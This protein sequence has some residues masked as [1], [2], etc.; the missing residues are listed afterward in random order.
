RQAGSARKPRIV[1]VHLGAGGAAQEQL[2]LTPKQ[3]RIELAA[4]TIDPVRI[5]HFNRGAIIPY[6]VTIEHVMAAMNDFIDFIQMVNL[7]LHE[8]DATR[9]EAML[10]PA[11]FSSIVGEFMSSNLP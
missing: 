2:V 4:C 9:L 5:E 11:N 7:R 8:N 10:M 6:G 3:K 1:S